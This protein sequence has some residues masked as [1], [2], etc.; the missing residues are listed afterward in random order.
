[1]WSPTILLGRWCSMLHPICAGPLANVLI[2]FFGIRTTRIE[3]FTSLFGH[4]SMTLS[5]SSSHL[6]SSESGQRLACF[7]LISS[8]WNNLKLGRY[9]RSASQQFPSDVEF[10]NQAWRDRRESSHVSPCSGDGERKAE[11]AVGTVLIKR[12]L[13]RKETA[14]FPSKEH[15][16]N[17][18]NYVQIQD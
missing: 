10:P 7:H 13:F 6:N 3:L 14:R 12:L 8:I 9:E 18:L 5:A 17:P 2:R 11:A 16:K 15:L 4:P 1:M